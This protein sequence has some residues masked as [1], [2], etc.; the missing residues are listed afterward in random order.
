MFLDRLHDCEHDYNERQYTQSLVLRHVKMPRDA[1]IYHR[2]Y[3]EYLETCWGN[4]LGIVVT[5]DVLWF[6]ALNEIVGLVKEMPEPHRHLFTNSH[7]KKKITVRTKEMVVMPLNHLVQELRSHVPTEATRFM[8]DFS[9]TTEAARHAQYAAFC[10]LCSPFYEY[11]MYACD[12]PAISIQGEADDW[13]RLHEQWIN[14][15]PLFR[16]AAE[17]FD[18]VGGIF[19]NCRENL[20]NAAWWK[21]MF[22]LE[23]CGSGHQTEMSGWLSDVYRSPPNGPGY[24]RNFPTNVAKVNYKQLDFGFEYVMQDGLF[25]SRQEGDFMAPEFGYTVHEKLKIEPE[26]YDGYADQEA[27]LKRLQ[28]R[29]A[30]L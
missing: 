19:K 25:C 11:G 28:A 21:G 29:I 9:T 27:A 5:P 30:Q 17:W 16:A 6:T 20:D 7:E 12:F 10:D 24:I 26:K 4:H 14:L 15:K 3:L 18:R 23:R 22:K 8:P 13:A 2:N 1:A